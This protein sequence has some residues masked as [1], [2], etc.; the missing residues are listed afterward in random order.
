MNSSPNEQT[1]TEHLADLRRVLLR[2]LYILAVGCGACLYFAEDIFTFVRQPIVPHLPSG[3]LV[4]T[5]P[6]D[7]FMSN[8]KVSFMAGVILTC[9]LW[10]YQIWLFIAPGLYKREKKIAISFIFFGTILFLCGFAFVYWLVLPTAFKFLLNIGHTVDV[11]M[12]TISDYISFFMMLTLVFG[13]AFEM[14]L[15]IVTLGMLGLV[16]DEFLRKNRRF[17]IMVMAIL[18]AIVTPPDAL[19]ML[20]LLAPLIVL[21]ELSIVLVKVLKPNREIVEEEA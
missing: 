10:L 1:F 7:K 17:A 20:S 19:S 15:I 21:Y 6:I 12:I 5:N 11:P 14:P 2:T 13:F 8:L 18:A 3:G 9:P 4:F 16:N